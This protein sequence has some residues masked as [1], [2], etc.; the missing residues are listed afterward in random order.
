MRT[1]IGASILAI[2]MLTACSGIGSPNSGSNVGI[3]AAKSVDTVH[4]KAS[5]AT[6]QSS[7]QSAQA[8]MGTIFNSSGSFNWNIFLGGV[9]FSTMGPAT[10]L[11]LASAFPT[12]NI[13]MLVLTAPQ[14]IANGLKC[15][16]DDVAATAGIANTDLNTALTTLNSALAQTTPGSPD[17][18]A[19]QAMI[20]EIQPLQ[21]SYTVLMQSLAGQ[22]NLVVTFLLQLPSL[23]TAAIP[24]PILSLFVGMGVSSFVQPIVVEV[25]HFQAQL[26]AL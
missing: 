10:Q 6:A 7:L 24:V 19:I 16:L 4:V 3:Q 21:T 17:A 20:N 22:L 8:A 2:C 11:C 23:A 18:I 9:D 5:V 25:M 13:A 1:Q 26:Q 14:D 15:I 12:Q